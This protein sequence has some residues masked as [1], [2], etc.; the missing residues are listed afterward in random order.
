MNLWREADYL[1]EYFFLKCNYRS[2]HNIGRNESHFGI[3]RVTYSEGG[4]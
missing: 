1:S 2:C 4:H 3:L